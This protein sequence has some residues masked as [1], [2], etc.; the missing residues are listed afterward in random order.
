[1]VSQIFRDNLLRGQIALIT[2]GGTGIGRVTA[3]ELAKLGVDVALLGRRSEPLE[4]VK[5]E[6]EALG[7]KAVTISCDIRN[8]DQVNSSVAKV[9]K[10]FGRIDILFN[11]AGGQ[12]IKPSIDMSPNGWNAVI[13]T[14]LSGT[15]FMSQQVAKQA[16]IPQKSGLIVNMIINMWRGIPAAA[17][18]GAARAGVDNLTKTLSLEWAAHKIRVNAVAPGT[19]ATE[20]LDNYPPALIKQ[21]RSLIPLKQVGQ[22][23]DV[24]WMI[25]Y[26][27]STAGRWLTGETICIDGGSQNWGSLWRIPDDDA[28]AGG[29]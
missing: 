29:Y 10:H 22:P 27:A 2:G 8:A 25:C 16:M 24:A 17:H 23:E 6:I 18:S 4:R 1:M 5:N 15:F 14:N 12:F 19:V 26:L 9:V 3:L 13:N 11:N 28:V 20:G 7:Q 21:L